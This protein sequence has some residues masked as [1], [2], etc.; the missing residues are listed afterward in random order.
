MRGEE[1]SAAKAFHL[2]EITR[3]RMEGLPVRGS[4]SCFRSRPTASAAVQSPENVPQLGGSPLCSK[5]LEGTPGDCLRNE[6]AAERLFLARF[7]SGLQIRCNSPR[8]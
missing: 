6:P 3:E 5:D 8:G 4:D 7:P 2:V 1:S